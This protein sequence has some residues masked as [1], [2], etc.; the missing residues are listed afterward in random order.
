MHNRLCAAGNTDAVL[1]VAVSTLEDGLAAV[2]AHGVVSVVLVG[3]ILVVVAIV[4]A[5]LR[6]AA[7]NA[8]AVLEVASS[9]LENHSIAVQAHSL[10]G[11]AALVYVLEVVAIV[12]ADGLDFLSTA[13]N[14]NAILEVARS[15]LEGHSLAV[16]A[17]SVVGVVAVGDILVVVVIVVAGRLDFLSTTGNTDAI[18][19]VASS[20]FS[21][22][23][24]ALIAGGLV[25]IH[26]VGLV[27]EVVLAMATDGVGIVAARLAGTILTINAHAVSVDHFIALRAGAG[28]I[29]VTIGG[30]DIIEMAALLGRLL[31]TAALALAILIAMRTGSPVNQLMTIVAAGHMDVAHVNIHFFPVTTSVV[32]IFFC[33]CHNAHHAE[34]HDESQQHCKNSFVHLFVSP[35]IGFISE[36]IREAPCSA[37]PGEL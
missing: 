32:A 27:L 36:S 16:L 5:L 6:S 33:K 21:N 8:N 7:S 11:V 14:A 34:N 12:V 35:Y 37:L 20:A 31:S 26:A 28:V 19:E 3:D 22:D 13:G 25:C 15:T 23:I 18:L 9:T 1:E 24:L 2:Q 30:E 17:H 4:V 29:A 10:V